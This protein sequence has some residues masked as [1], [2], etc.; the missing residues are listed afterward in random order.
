MKST[1]SKDLEWGHFLHRAQK[2]F[3][4]YFLNRDWYVY[5]SRSQIAQNNQESPFV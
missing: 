2:A 5:L 4:C 3:L 1:L